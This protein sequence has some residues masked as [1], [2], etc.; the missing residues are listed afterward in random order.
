MAGSSH[1]S[2]TF[3]AFVRFLAFIWSPCLCLSLSYNLQSHRWL[4]MFYSSVFTIWTIILFYSMSCGTILYIYL[5]PS[6]HSWC[7][8]NCRTGCKLIINYRYF[9]TI[10]E[11]WTTNCP[12]YSSF[13]KSILNGTEEL[14]FTFV[15]LQH[16]LL[17]MLEMLKWPMQRA[18]RRRAKEILLLCFNFFF[19]G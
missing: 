17:C 16:D 5:F 12:Q 8:G 9:K 13:I 10:A 1:P 4:W 18:K 15:A 6:N 2:S 7:F 14:I 19:V 3:G 11:K